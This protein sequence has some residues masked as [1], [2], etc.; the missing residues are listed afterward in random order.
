MRQLALSFLLLLLCVP[1]LAQDDDRLVLLQDGI[2]WT[3]DIVSGE[4]SD[5]GQ[6]LPDRQGMRMSPSRDYI[7]YKVFPDVFAEDY[8][9]E[10]PCGGGQMPENMML[11]NTVT[12][13]TLVVGGQPEGAT[14]SQGIA[15]SIPVWSPDGMRLAWTEYVEVSQLVVYDVTTGSLTVIADS[16]PA[17]ALNSSTAEITSWTLSGILISNVEYDSSDYSKETI[18]F[19]VYAP[20]G[21]VVRAVP[22]QFVNPSRFQMVNQ[23]G[24]DLI[25]VLDNGEWQ[26][27]NVVSGDF[28]TIERGRFALVSPASPETSV[29]V[30]VPTIE[31]DTNTYIHQIQSPDGDDLGTIGGFYPLIL[32][33]GRVLVQRIEGQ[34]FLL[35]RGVDDSELL[36]FSEI[37][38]YSGN[39]FPPDMTVIVPTDE[40]LITQSNCAGT[41]FDNRLV[42][43]APAYVLGNQPNNT[44]SVAGLDGELVGQIAGGEV[45]T[46]I[47]GPTCRDNIAWWLVNYGDG[48]EDWT[49]EGIGDE[50]FLEP[51]CPEDQCIPVR[52]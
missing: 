48:D 3:Y 41:T 9:R 46:V 16:V 45:I 40:R 30:L 22:P 52:G 8:A 5:V 14:M 35:W 12:G 25:A 6:L 21:R 28:V 23:D 43:F 37:G 19:T 26:F 32:E 47:N 1:V 7:A 11:F 18:G 20:D 10:C 38:G 50:Y 34:Q 4:L 49:A 17:Q 44:R 29:R 42:M 13:E 15:R 51:G 2:V 39:L 31:D 24:D 33:S 36:D 27:I